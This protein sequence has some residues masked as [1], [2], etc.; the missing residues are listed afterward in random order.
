MY[1]YNQNMQDMYINNMWQKHI[2]ILYNKMWISIVYIASL[3]ILKL[4]KN[5][6][7]K[8][9]GEGWKNCILLSST[10]FSFFVHAKKM[11]KEA[12]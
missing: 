6:Y 3:W 8:M 2:N 9:K 5:K 4:Y 10:I 7:D 1:I 12:C 11:T